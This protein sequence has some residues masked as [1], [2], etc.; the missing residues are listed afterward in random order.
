MTPVVHSGDAA[1]RPAPAWICVLIDLLAT[2]SI[3]GYFTAGF[4]VL[5]APFY[6]LAAGVAADRQRAFQ[7]LNHIFHRGFFLICRLVMPL[8]TWRID[9]A[10]RAVRAVLDCVD[11]CM[12]Q[13]I[14]HAPS[15]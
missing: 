15:G 8:Q 11:C 14:H 10:V 5:F 2:L 3:W 9:P 12:M 7:W 13:G 4:V 1:R 6:L